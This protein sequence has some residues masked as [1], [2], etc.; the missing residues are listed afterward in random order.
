ML[1]VFILAF[2]WFGFNPGS[3]L[4]GTDLRISVVAVNTMLASCAGMLAAMIYMWKNTGKPDP[5]M[6]GNGLPGRPGRHH[7]ALRLRQ[8]PRRLH[9]RP[10]LRHLVVRGRPVPGMEAEAG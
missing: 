6:T 10:G 4:A 7:R 3:T 8:P 5:A 9:H 1:G 2:G